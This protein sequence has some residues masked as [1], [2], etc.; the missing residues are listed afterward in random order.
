MPTDNP[1]YDGAGPNAD[2]IWAYGLRNPFR[3]SIDTVTGRMYIGDVGG[4]ETAN[5]IEE[6]QRRSARRELRL[7]DL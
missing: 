6:V 3:M 5:S 1:F 7:A 2:A 4:N